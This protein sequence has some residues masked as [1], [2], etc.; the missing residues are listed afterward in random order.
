MCGHRDLDPWCKVERL[1]NLLSALTRARGD[2]VSYFEE[3]NF[4][5]VPSVL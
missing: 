1:L 2:G 4:L 5:L 3:M